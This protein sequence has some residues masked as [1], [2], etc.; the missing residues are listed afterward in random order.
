MIVFSFSL[1]GKDPIYNKGILENARILNN[2]FPKYRVYIYLADDVPVQTIECLQRF[3][4]VNIINVRNSANKYKNTLNRFLAIDEPDC[5]IMFS[6]D[7]DSRVHLRDQACIIDFIESDKLLHIIRDHPAHGTRIMAGL[8]G[9]KKAALNEP[10]AIKINRFCKGLN[11]E[12]GVD[13]KFLKE[14]IY[15]S[16]FTNALIQDDRGFFEPK[17]MRTKFR[18][19]TK[20]KLYCGKVHIYNTEGEETYKY[21]DLLDY[22][23][24]INSVSS[25][26]EQSALCN[27]IECNFLRHRNP[28]ISKTHCCR[29]CYKGKGHGIACEKCTGQPLEL[30]VGTE[31]AVKLP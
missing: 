22:G 17:S 6:R 13:Q 27:N 25:S 15:P 24:K 4:N 20:H 28:Q 3:P 30:K 7:A 14:M 8:F 26:Q 31:S 5:S 9:I 19:N 2:V 16:L 29:K 18:V 23:I 21:S 1:F 12:R 10:M 11:I